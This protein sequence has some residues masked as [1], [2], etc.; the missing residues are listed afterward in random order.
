MQEALLKSMLTYM[1]RKVYNVDIVKVDT[2]IDNSFKR[3]LEI[4]WL[5]VIFLLPIFL[6]PASHQAF[7]LNKALLFQ[8]LVI[9]MLALY[10]AKQIY[11]TRGSNGLNWRD[12]VNHPL[13]LAVLV[14]GL[15]AI[16]ATAV[17][18]T[19]FISFWGS[20][21]RKD[22]LLTIICWILF[23]LIVAQNMQQRQQL[24]RAIYT[25]LLSSGIVSILGIL[26]YF[27]PDI[28][29]NYR[30][31]YRGVIST[32][33]NALSL[34]GFLAMVI[35]FTI[36]LIVYVWGRWGKPKNTMTLFGLIALLII[37]F[38]CLWLAQY[39]ITLLLYIIAPFI[40]LLLLG[41][42]RRRRLLVGIGMLSLAAIGTVAGMILMPLLFQGADNGAVKN[43]DPEYAISAER[44]ELITLGNRVQHWR[45]TV[46]M[47]LKSPEVPLSNDRLSSIRTFI[48]Y[49]PETFIIT[50]QGFYPEGLKSQRTH[51]SIMM[52][53]PHNYYLYLAAVTGLLG[54]I[55]Y[56]SILAVFFYLLFRYIRKVGF[57][58]DRLILIALVASMIGYMADRLFNPSTILTDLM[59]WLTL[60][61]VPVIA[62]LSSNPDS[63]ETNIVS[64]KAT[65]NND[66]KEFSYPNVR[67]IIS[68]GCAIILIIAGVSI[69]F[70]PVLADVQLQKAL[71]LQAVGNENALEAFERVVEIEPKEAAYWG[72]LGAYSYAEARRVVEE[73]LKT[74]YLT[75]SA[76]AYARACELE[77][78][79]AY[80]Y[81]IMADMH[82]YWANEGASDKWP[83]AFSLYDK[84]L[85]L[86]PRNAVILNKWALAL[87][88][89]GDLT[90][91]REKLDDAASIDPEWSGTAFL[92]G[93]L[94]VKEGKPEEA[95]YEM[96]RP[97]REAP[98]NLNYFTDL[99]IQFIAYDMVDSV[100]DAL[101]SYMQQTTG[102]WVPHAM[103]GVTS[104]CNGNPERSFKEFDTAMFL[105]PDRD[106]GDLF[107]PIFGLAIRSP[108]FRMLLSSVKSEWRTKLSRTDDSKRVLWQFDQLMKLPDLH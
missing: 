65:K 41:I 60:S 93:F 26:Q 1:N 80:R 38:W 11:G 107:K 14:F 105:V 21:H 7:Y 84:A 15:V 8:F 46:D 33:G 4:C 37:Q 5:S 90:Q 58:I 55:S 35:P 76:A 75:L 44:L 27:Y 89:E 51:Y 69:T 85:Q 2:T 77:R 40:F 53:R 52:S 13:H 92:S 57:N 81:Y 32:T 98:Y 10:V 54:L 102:D 30:P 3:G 49:G 16:I 96:I 19:P 71:D 28:I 104:L 39:S 29:F 67:W 87:I 50:Y 61:L 22:G 34:S 100:E 91:A 25:L 17:S 48:G 103:L 9:V 43:K 12:V 20:W 64:E 66:G 83:I 42:V 88:I 79:M 24:L 56:L 63:S 78:F 59:F 23:F 18:I 70:R 82:V 68:V 106:A 47:I 62:R 31:G 97:I 6:N 45:N 73:P 101:T 108:N 86:F 72:Y 36:A 95:A 74:Y 99:C 94:T